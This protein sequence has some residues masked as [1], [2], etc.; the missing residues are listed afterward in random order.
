MK[1]FTLNDIIE[2]Y[3]ICMNCQR[4][5]RMSFRS[6]LSG[7]VSERIPIISSYSI[8][9]PLSIN[10][11][12]SL[13]IEIVRSSNRVISGDFEALAQ[14]F[15]HRQFI[16]RI[17]CSMCVSLIET[18][19]IS[20][21]FQKGVLNP[22]TLDYEQIN[23]RDGYNVYCATTIFNTVDPKTKIEAF[24]FKKDVSLQIFD[25]K[26]S[27]NHYPK[28]KWKQKEKFLNKVSI[29]RNFQ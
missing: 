15:Q 6:N 7:M 16:I 21:D 12:S 23:I 29:L 25:F 27:L 9:I 10:Y 22:L 1:K 8:L 19:I 14:Y 18:K 13:N 2:Y 17:G 20:F 28:Y 11:N 5:T 24:S 4:P 26:A 3:P